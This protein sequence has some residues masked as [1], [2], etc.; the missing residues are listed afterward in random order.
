MSSGKRRQLAWKVR[1]DRHPIEKLLWTHFHC[2]CLDFT[3]CHFTRLVNRPSV[4]LFLES[5]CM[6][7]HTLSG[8]V[9]SRPSRSAVG[10][11]Q[12]QAYPDCNLSKT[13]T[14]VNGFTACPGCPKFLPMQ[15]FA[16]PATL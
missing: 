10:V 11:L 3:L 13:S 12:L 7:G 16:F 4:I 6:S 5:C 2:A 8:R 1:R 9:R 15:T 14:Q